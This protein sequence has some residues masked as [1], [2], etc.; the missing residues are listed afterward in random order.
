[1]SSPKRASLALS[2]DF[3]CDS[4]CHSF[5]AHGAVGGGVGHFG[6]TAV[7][8][9]GVCGGVF[10][11]VPPF[12][13]AG[14]PLLLPQLFPTAELVERVFVPLSVSFSFWLGMYS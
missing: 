1:M 10:D 7:Q 14:V 6:G 2:L 13:Q 3:F 12:H 5:W 8:V 9:G 11:Q 4:F